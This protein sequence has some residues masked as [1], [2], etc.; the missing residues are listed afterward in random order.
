[1][2]E[3]KQLFSIFIIAFISEINIS[4]E[5]NL[6]FQDALK[7]F[8]EVAYSYY[9]RGKYIQYNFPK[10]HHFSPEEATA[11]NINYMVCSGF[12]RSVYGELL[13]ITIPTGTK[14]LLSYSKKNL[15]NP[16]VV[17]YYSYK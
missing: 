7:A 5:K 10:V 15:G 1:M 6:K 17:L 3:F 13:N 11:Q 8:Q 4:Y 2:K 9:M 16:E 14:S 12:T